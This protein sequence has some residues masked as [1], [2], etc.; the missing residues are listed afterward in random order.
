MVFIIEDK[1]KENE[2]GIVQSLVKV[3]LMQFLKYTFN[4]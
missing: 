1:Y 2:I 3:N 4:D